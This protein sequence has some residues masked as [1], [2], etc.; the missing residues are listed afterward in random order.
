MLC[1][2]E[3]VAANAVTGSCL[4]AR[5]AALEVEDLKLVAAAGETTVCKPRVREARR[6]ADWVRGRE[7]EVSTI[8]TEFLV[9]I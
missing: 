8:L 7:R 6:P 4:E 5:A 1:N 2:V 9:Y 3:V